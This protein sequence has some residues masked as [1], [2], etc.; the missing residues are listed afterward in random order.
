M[1]FLV[2]HAIAT[3]KLINYLCLYFSFLTSI[4]G[5]LQ[6][7]F[8]NKVVSVYSLEAEFTRPLWTYGMN[9]YE[10]VESSKQKN[11]I[12]CSYR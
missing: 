2:G 3:E 8:E 4:V 6:I 12:A 9:S 5:W 11:L 7:E 1:N 10:F